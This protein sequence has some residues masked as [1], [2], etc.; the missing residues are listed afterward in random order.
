M[1]RELPFST[2]ATMV[3]TRSFTVF[4]ITVHKSNTLCLRSITLG[5]WVS[6]AMFATFTKFWESVTGKQTFRNIGGIE[7]R[8]YLSIRMALFIAQREVHNRWCICLITD[9]TTFHS[10]QVLWT[11][12]DN[13]WNFSASICSKCQSCY[14]TGNLMSDV[15]SYQLEIIFARF[16]FSCPLCA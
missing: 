2:L 15:K 1:A 11:W 12:C 5:F 13:L 14:T 16:T 9:R 6:Q 3:G 10:A 4:N 8:T 7:F